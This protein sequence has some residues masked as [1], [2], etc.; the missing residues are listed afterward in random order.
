MTVSSWVV[1]STVL[2]VSVASAG[3]PDQMEAVSGALG[4]GESQHDLRSQ[5]R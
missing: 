4:R 3:H 1:I 2:P 5:V